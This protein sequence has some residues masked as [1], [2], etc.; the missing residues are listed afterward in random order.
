V[1]SR[2]LAF[3]F[4]LALA[5]AIGCGW[6]ALTWWVVAGVPA[7]WQRV[8]VILGWVFVGGPLVFVTVVIA[9]LIA[10]RD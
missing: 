5:V 1:R 3:V 10:V 7:G 9:G 2:E 4:F 8:L 6:N